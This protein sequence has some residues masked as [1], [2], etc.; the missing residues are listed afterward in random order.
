MM[1]LKNNVEMTQ[2]VSV[3]LCSRMNGFLLMRHTVFNF[4][5]VE[6]LCTN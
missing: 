3:G 5:V 6:L 2:V 4:F 1:Y